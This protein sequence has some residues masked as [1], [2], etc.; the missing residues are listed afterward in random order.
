MNDSVGVNLIILS[1]K[2]D[3]AQSINR[4]LRDAGHAVRCTRV[5]LLQQFKEAVEQNSPHLI[6]AFP[7]EPDL[8]IQT[9]CDLAKHICPKTP[10]IAVRNNVSEDTITDAMRIGARDVVSL[11]NGERLVFV[12]ERELRSY[13]IENG[14]EDVLFSA[15]QYKQELHSLKGAVTEAI[16][17]IQE[18]IVVAANPP[19]LEM[20]GYAE[21]DELIGMPVMD[22]FADDDQQ[23]LKGALVACLKDK[24]D[25]S[26]L[27]MNGRKT[28][29]ES[30]NVELALESI[31]FEG[32]PAVRAIIAMP[33]TEEQA[34]EELLEEAVQKDPVTGFYHRHYFLNK[35]TERLENAPSGGVRCIVYLR[36][37][38]FSKVHDDIGLLGTEQILIQL[39]QLLRDYMQSNDLYGRFGGTMFTAIIERGSMAEVESW[40]EQVRKAVSE[41]V[42]EVEERSTTLTCSIGLMEIDSTEHTIETLL[43]E[44][45]GACRAARDAGGDTVEMSQITVSKQQAREDDEMWVNK[46]RSALMENRLRLIHQPVASLNEDIENAH[47]TL[48]RMVDKDGNTILPKDFMP[49]AERAGLTKNIDRWVVGASFS[50]VASKRP[51]VVFI[52]LSQQSVVDDTTGDWIVE[53]LQSAGIDAG[54]ICFQVNEELA[55]KHLRHVMS[56]SE[57]LRGAGFKFALDHFGGRDDSTRFLQHVPMDYIKL[58]GSIMQGLHKDKALQEKIK[59][60]NILARERNIKSV[61]EQVQNANTMAVLWQLGISYMQGNYVEVSDVVLEDTSTSITAITMASPE[62]EEEGESEQAAQG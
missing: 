33:N 9:V 44:V 54:K 48:V 2:D 39:S 58:D 37:D 55:I 4:L 3:N 50:F 5:A 14:L 20:F 40:A 47:D 53:G 38:N 45:E 24:W 7:D 36:P 8:D 21:E 26:E 1:H 52:R 62:G 51:N 27:R 43:S 18:G 34:P 32:D 35:C 30:F 41:E 22:L 56:L 57:T 49:A 11:D 60:L 17:D 28:D 15:K 61:A 19:W 10:V 29:G 6:M 59:N 42:F 13:H 46:L 16:A 25:D 12:F 31:S 23:V